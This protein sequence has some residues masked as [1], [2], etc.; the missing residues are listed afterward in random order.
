MTSPA[1]VEQ[2]PQ[3]VRA[4][5]G[6][7][8]SLHA[9]QLQKT[10]SWHHRLS[11]FLGRGIIAAIWDAA[12]DGLGRENENLHITRVTKRFEA[13][14]MKCLMPVWCQLEYSPHH[15]LA[16][17]STITASS[18][19]FVYTNVSFMRFRHLPSSLISNFRQRRG[20]EEEEE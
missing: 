3:H 19:K 12:A 15:P 18:G 13:R 14:H 5:R 20:K 7:R 2:R 9:W 10:F 17:N 1:H 11:L 4:W 6:L 16:S 8:S